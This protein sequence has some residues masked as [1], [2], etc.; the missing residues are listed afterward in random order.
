V[1][2]L[3][4]HDQQFSFN[5]FPIENLVHL[6]NMLKQTGQLSLFRCKKMRVGGV[7]EVL[8][9]AHPQ[10]TLEGLVNSSPFSM[11]LMHMT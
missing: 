9:D 11:T 2:T 10:G 6:F 4:P 5:R 1:V 3:T 8:E 7:H